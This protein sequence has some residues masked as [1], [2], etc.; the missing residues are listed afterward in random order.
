M[1]E[2]RQRRHIEAEPLR[3]ARPVQEW[4]L[5]GLQLLHSVFQTMH[6]GQRL[7]VRAGDPLRLLEAV[8]RGQLGRLRDARQ[9]P[10]A[11]PTAAVAFVPAQ[12]RV[13]RS[14]IAVCPGLLA[15]LELRL[16]AHVGP[17]G[18]VGCLVLVAVRH[19]GLGRAARFLL[20]SHRLLCLV[21]NGWI[22][23]SA[24]QTA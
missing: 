5:N 7:A 23:F 11:Q 14:V 17:H 3:L 12:S 13:Q 4:P 19:L 2:E 21:G 18:A 24:A 22:V 8:R 10:L 6:G 20:E 9:Q 16:C 15:L 1:D